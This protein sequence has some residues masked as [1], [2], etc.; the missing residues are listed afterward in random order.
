M[1][2]FSQI[3]VAYQWLLSTPS[4]C[5]ITVSEWEKER[6]WELP[7]F[8]SQHPFTSH[9]PNS[10]TLP[11]TLVS[12]AQKLWKRTLLRLSISTHFALLL[13]A[14]LLLWKKALL[15]LH[16]MIQSLSNQNP[17]SMALISFPSGTPSFL[18]THEK[19]YENW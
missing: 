9:L 10:L 16:L 14:Q 19:S 6:K 13:V 5:F 18:L 17:P 3:G 1:G 8:Q 7:L 11:L 12:V 2:P 15:L 4:L